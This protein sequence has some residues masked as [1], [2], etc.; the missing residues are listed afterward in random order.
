MKQTL[1]LLGAS[2]V[3]IFALCACRQTCKPFYFVQISDPQMGF[4][5]KGAIER[6]VRLLGNT[7]DAINALNPPFVIVTGDM[8]SHWNNAVEAAAYDSLISCI[9]PDIK[10]WHVPGNHDFRPLRE[11]GKGSD[12]F[13]M[14]R[15]GYDRFAFTYN[16]CL[17]LGFNSCYVMDGVEDKEEEQ[18]EW[19][20]SNLKKYSGKVDKIL[21]FT[22]CSIIKTAPDEEEDYFCFHSPYREKY[23][24]LCKDYG[25]D[26]VFSGHYHRA[27]YVEHDGTKFV[28][29]TASGWPLGDGF[30]GI[31]VIKVTPESVTFDMVPPEKAVI[32]QL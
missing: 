3:L 15:Y 25:V 23:L 2:F 10:V 7:V 32:P 14:E 18:Y 13:Y 22:H 16:G 30:S 6:S 19:M 1:K 5:E 27:R 24:K 28:T 26:A 8:L 9:N 4:K 11:D 29:C 12:T 20:V 17:L 21:L 31:N